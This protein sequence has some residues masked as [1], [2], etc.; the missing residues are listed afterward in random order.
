MGFREEIRTA[1]FRGVEFAVAVSNEQGGR[2]A[3]IFEFP[4]R[5]EPFVDDLGRASRQFSIEV[6]VLGEDHLLQAQDLQLA[7]ETRGPGVFVSPYRGS[8]LV[9]CLGFTRNENASDS[10]ITSF[11]ITFIEAG[12]APQPSSAVDTLGEIRSAAEASKAPSKT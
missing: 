6:F 8:L 12:T 3:V 9:Q 2:R 4:L 11:G 10:G 7:L 1:S 5:D